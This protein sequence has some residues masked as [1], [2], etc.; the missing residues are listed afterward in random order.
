[1]TKK[2]IIGLVLAFS[3]LFSMPVKAEGDMEN[4]RDAE[5]LSLEH[6]KSIE[7]QQQ[8]P[9]F[10][11]H[12]QVEALFDE[13]TEVQPYGLG[14]D[15]YE[16][17]NT[18]ETAFPYEQVNKLKTQVTSKYDLF[19][20]GMRNASLHSADDVDWFSVN[21]TAG[22]TYFVDLR[23]IGKTNWYIELY[24]FD[25]AGSG[26]YYTTD[27]AERPVYE[28]WQEKYFYFTAEDT[29][30][31]YIRIANGGEWSSDL[32]YFFYVGPAIQFFDIVDMPTYDSVQI[33]GSDYK[34]YTCDLRNAVPPTTEIVNLSMAD[35]FWYGETCMEIEKYMSTGGAKYSNRRGGGS[36]T[37]NSISGV[38]LGQL[39]TIGGRCAKG[40]HFSTWAG[41]LNGRFGCVMAPYPGNELS[42]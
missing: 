6:L 28:K 19:S 25:G 12:D 7:L 23:N 34:T 18:P 26:Y 38:S 16:P 41:V 27:P 21:L 33:F 20:L 13:E 4:I 37:I 17:N 40:I 9:V 8:A 1:M 35:K 2:R 3:M 22:E 31:Y 39:W 14:G 10:L 36:D 15:D 24:Y 42:F 5:K 11:G 30:T 29:G 32:Y